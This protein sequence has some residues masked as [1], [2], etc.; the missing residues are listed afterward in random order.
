[1]VFQLVEGSG[2]NGGDE[3]IE[4]ASRVALTRVTDSVME[5]GHEW[6]ISRS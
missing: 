4:K 5:E 1:M 6:K 3:E 2:G